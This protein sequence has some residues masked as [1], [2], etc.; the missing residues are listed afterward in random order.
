MDHAAG[1]DMSPGPDDDA[2]GDADSGMDEGSVADLRPGMDAGGWGRFWMEQRHGKGEGGMG[3]RDG[4]AGASQVDVQSV[5]HDQGT[6]LGFL[7]LGQVFG[8]HEEAELIS[9]SPFQG[10]RAAQADAGIA[11]KSPAQAGLQVGQRQDGHG[12]LSVPGPSEPAR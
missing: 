9:F 1:A 11:P 7:G 6:C 3:V 12:K 4:Q 10:C 8:M 5:W 2:G